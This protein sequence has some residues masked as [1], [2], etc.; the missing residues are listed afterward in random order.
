MPIVKKDL[1]GS[2]GKT[3][4]NANP[5]HIVQVTDNNI[6]TVFKRCV[7]YGR[8]TLIKRY[9]LIINRTVIDTWLLKALIIPSAL[10]TADLLK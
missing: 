10:Q 6:T 3:G 7:L 8:T 4:Y 2:H 1:N 5:N 9:K